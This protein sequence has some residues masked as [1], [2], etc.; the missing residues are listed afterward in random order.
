MAEAPGSRPVIWWVRRDLRLA[1]N[2]ALRAAADSGRPV[3]P[4]FV[5]D[6]KRPRA[7]GGA[8]LWWL[9][10]SLKALAADLEKAGSP[11]V[12]R[13]G[14]T[15]ETLLAVAKE[16]GADALHFGR[17]YDGEDGPLEDEA[18]RALGEAGVR[19]ESHVGSLLTEPGQVKTGSGEAFKVYG[20]FW[21]ALKAQLGPVKLIP[22]VRKLHSPAKPVRSEP[23]AGWRLY[24]AAPDWAVDFAGEPGEAGAHRALDAFVHGPLAR[25]QLERA[26]PA[27]A[28]TSRLSPHLHWGDVSSRQV[29]VAACN[30]AEAHGHEDQREKF[31]SELAWRDF[32]TTVL[33]AHP[34][35]GSE[36]YLGRLEGLR[37]RKDPAG[38]HA[39]SRGLTGYPIVDA[40]MRE[41][42]RSGWMHNRVR[43]ITASFLIKDLLI[44]WRMG[45]QWFW[46]CL[47]DAD[48]GNNG[49]NWQWVAGTGP[50]AS[51]FFRV[52]TPVG[53]G[54]KFD[55]HGAYVRKWC[56]ELEKLPDAY[57]HRPWEA[58][59]DVLAA[60]GVTLGETYPHPIVDHAEARDRALKAYQAQ[61]T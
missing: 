49:I 46:D 60:A 10:R 37:W 16:T 42:W 27:E 51:P 20:P 14:P 5:L 33:Q 58:P 45:E 35:L 52:F 13:R 32:S 28:A 12:L 9:E 29:W 57:V 56:P 40:G 54:E 18:V 47:V 17:M 53:Q 36:N 61:K 22:A 43:M 8:G 15:V 30:A 31:L 7:P 3:I 39:W 19:A 48:E 44:D 11:L 6:M 38:F 41:L 23:L 50:D 26:Q 4:L 2:A 34:H 21:R 55:P 1:D 25:Y 24:P 59:A